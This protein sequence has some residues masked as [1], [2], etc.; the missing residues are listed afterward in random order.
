MRLGSYELRKPWV[1]M[2]SVP[3]E[4]Q[5]YWAIR[6]SIGEDIAK[7]IED[8]IE[9]IMPPVDEVELAIY[10]TAHHC[11]K[12]ARSQEAVTEEKST[13]SVVPTSEVYTGSAYCVSCQQNRD[14]EGEIRISNSGR[15]VAYGVCNV[16]GA[17]V[18]RILGKVN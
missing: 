1:K 6:K 8:E 15:N 2:V 7:A 11:A 18:T 13:A 4:E 17:Q 12:I 16:C 14:F 9:K 3:I 10:E 5:V